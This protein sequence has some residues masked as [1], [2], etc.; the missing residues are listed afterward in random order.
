[1]SLDEDEEFLT[2]ALA[3]QAAALATGDAD[4]LVM[5]PWQGVQILTPA[6]FVALAQT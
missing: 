4:F 2:L 6:A 5:H 3:C 1:M